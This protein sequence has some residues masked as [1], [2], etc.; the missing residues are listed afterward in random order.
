MTQGPSAA[1]LHSAKTHDV[2]R[3]AR[4]AEDACLLDADTGR[5]LPVSDGRGHCAVPQAAAPSSLVCWLATAPQPCMPAIGSSSQ[6]LGTREF[7]ALAMSVYTGWP[8]RAR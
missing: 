6:I 2:N 4:A 7:E 8:E 3:R 1:A 5:A